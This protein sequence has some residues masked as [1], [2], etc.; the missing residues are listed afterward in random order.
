MI[1]EIEPDTPL[2]IQKKSIE[3]IRKELASLEE[4]E[5][6]LQLDE[7]AIISLLNRRCGCS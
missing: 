3:E 4:E 1:D 6:E 2:V 5:P 7:E